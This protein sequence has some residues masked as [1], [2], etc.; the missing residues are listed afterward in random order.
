[1]IAE[2]AE[3]GEFVELEGSAEALQVIYDP[4]GGREALMLKYSALVRER[5]DSQLGFNDPAAIISHSQ[6]AS[7]VLRD[8]SGAALIEVEGGD[9]LEAVHAQLLEVYG[10]G[11]EVRVEALEPGDRVRVRGR[12]RTLSAESSPHRGAAWRAV[13]HEVEVER[14]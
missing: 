14:T 1:M 4:V 10:A 11:I 2:L 9:N 13:L 6:G 5:A 7:F 8:A 12:V 3:L